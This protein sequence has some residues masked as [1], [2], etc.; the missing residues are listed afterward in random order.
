MI[1]ERRPFSQEVQEDS[2][3]SKEQEGSLQHQVLPLSK[4]WTLLERLSSPKRGKGKMDK[5]HH[6]HVVEEEKP[7]RKKER[8]TDLDDEYV[9]IAALTVQ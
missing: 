7:V 4:G 5:R 3:V 2:E 8:R 9:C 6:A 1:L